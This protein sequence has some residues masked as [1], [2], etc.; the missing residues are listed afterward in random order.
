MFVP[1]LC[2]LL[3]LGPRL[4]AAAPLTGCFHA[5]AKRFTHFL[6]FWLPWML[7][8][9]I[10]TES[11]HG[12][13]AT[14]LMG[15]GYWTTPNANSVSY[16]LSKEKLSFQNAGKRRLCFPSIIRFRCACG[17]MPSCSWWPWP[18]VITIAMFIS[19]SS[20]YQPELCLPH[21]YLRARCVTQCVHIN[22]TTYFRAS[23][24]KATS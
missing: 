2:A 18:T 12:A 17:T 19:T 15:A 13:M 10:L 5:N 3:T 1:L 24:S 4:G 20:L 8:I 6:L 16:Y 7:S 14:V 22:H 23:S 9:E 11:W 21:Q